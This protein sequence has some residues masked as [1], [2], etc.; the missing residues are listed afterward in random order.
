[1]SFFLCEHVHVCVWSQKH[2]W[3]AT[4]VLLSAFHLASESQS[5]QVCA[6][7]GYRDWTQVFTLAWSTSPTVPS[8]QPYITLQITKW[9]K[10]KIRKTQW[11]LVVALN[12]SYVVNNCIFLLFLPFPSGL[13]ICCSHFLLIFLVDKPVSAVHRTLFSCT[14]TRWST[15]SGKSYTLYLTTYFEDN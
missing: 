2:A 9:T 1:M 8:P 4:L 6:T 10:D 12:T 15:K 11:H 14:H 3:R 5:H 7:L 13:F